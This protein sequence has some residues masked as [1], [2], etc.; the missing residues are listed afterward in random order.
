MRSLNGRVDLAPKLKVEDEVLK[1]E[2]VADDRPGRRGEVEAGEL[3]NRVVHDGRD[4]ARLAAQ[5][6]G[7]DLVDVSFL[8]ECK[9]EVSFEATEEGRGGA[10]APASSF[11]RQLSL[12]ASTSTPIVSSSCLAVDAFSIHRRRSVVPPAAHSASSSA[13]RRTTTAFSTSASPF[14][15]TTTSSTCDGMAALRIAG[16]LAADASLTVSLALAGAVRRLVAERAK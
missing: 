13:R 11:S 2:R 10:S 12:S 8:C 15:R 7:E 16:P 9:T 6:Q 1:G 5:V 3:E 4:E 14:R